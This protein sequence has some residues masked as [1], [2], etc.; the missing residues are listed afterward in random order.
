MRA[1]MKRV[2]VFVEERS[3]GETAHGRRGIHPQ[4]PARPALPAHAHAKSGTPQG[5]AAPGQLVWDGRLRGLPRLDIM[6]HM[7]SA[8]FLSRSILANSFGECM[9]E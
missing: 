7:H 1:R 9:P 4:P 3:G 5:R 8:A 6:R 2:F